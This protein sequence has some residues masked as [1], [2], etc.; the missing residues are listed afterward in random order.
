[1]ESNSQST[2]EGTY[3]SPPRSLTHARSLGNITR[4]SARPT[5]EEILLPQAPPPSR[6]L[7]P[8]FE[9]TRNLQPREETIWDVLLRQYSMGRNMGRLERDYVVVDAVSP[10]HMKDMELGPFWFITQ[11]DSAS[12]FDSTEQAKLTPGITIKL[13][14]KEAARYSLTFEHPI[15]F[16]E[17]GRIAW[18]EEGLHVFEFNAHLFSRA[19]IPF[20]I[21]ERFMLIA[22]PD[23]FIPSHHHLPII[24]DVKSLGQRY[25][26]GLDAVQPPLRSWE[27]DYSARLEQKRVRDWKAG[28]R[29]DLA[30]LWFQDQMRL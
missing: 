10:Y 1:M 23:H 4:R 6:S 28:L 25:I 24:E 3:L 18:R 27:K 29:R 21:Y 13:E 8:P 2:Y 22:V 16:G 19:R 30:A 17:L 5:D 15:L 7:T 12:G 26:E 20:P 11:L 9:H 14:D